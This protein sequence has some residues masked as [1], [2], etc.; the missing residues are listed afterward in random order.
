M[1]KS[2]PDLSDAERA[3]YEWQMWTPDV[4]ELGQQKLKAASVLVSRLGGVGGTVAYYLAA[5]GIG[6]LVL[7]HA[8]DVKP[9]DLNRQLLMTTDWL[10]KPRI[11]SAARRLQELNP[12]VEIHTTGENLSAGNAA[13][14]V[15]E[16]DIVVDAAPL[17]H[18]RFAMN[19]AAVEQKKPLVECAMYYLDAQLTTII[20]GVTPCL[21]C[22]YPDDPPTWKREFPVFGAV[23]GMVA[24]MAAVEVIKLIT[25]IGEPIA[26][27]MLWVNLRTMDF[28]KLPIAR[29]SDCRICAGVNDSACR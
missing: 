1:T 4:G 20:P 23:S 12:N 15:G 21:S 25:G 17:F 19:H 7:A 22:I 2:L 8:G 10:G 29:R 16:V 3:R 18:E 14:L 11:E 26:G 6:K 24:A 27:K 5:A 13:A 28:R 9:S